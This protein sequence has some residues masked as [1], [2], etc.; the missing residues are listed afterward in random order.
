VLLPLVPA[1]FGYAIRNAVRIRRIV[2]SGWAK[3]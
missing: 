3:A 2:A 1:L